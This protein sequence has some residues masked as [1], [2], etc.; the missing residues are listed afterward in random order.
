MSFNT[1]WFTALAK[2]HQVH[3]RLEVHMATVA[4]ILTAQLSLA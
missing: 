2:K 3:V 4:N 1:F